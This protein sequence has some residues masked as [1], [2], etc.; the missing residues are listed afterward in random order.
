MLLLQSKPTYLGPSLGLW[1]ARVLEPPPMV[2]ILA[3]AAEPVL[4]LR[5][6]VILTVIR[7]RPARL[8]IVRIPGMGLLLK[9]VWVLAIAGCAV[10]TG[11]TS[12]TGTSTRCGGGSADR[13]AAARTLLTGV[14]LFLVSL[15]LCFLLLLLVTIQIIGR[16]DHGWKDDLVVGLTGAGG[17][18]RLCIL[19]TFVFL[20]AVVIVQFG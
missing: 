4:A 5:P 13:L 1:P 9:M 7:S 12:T 3:V 10:A 17:P 11:P 18:L 2:R 6:A 14:R 15:L 19:F 20:L 16:C 8:Y